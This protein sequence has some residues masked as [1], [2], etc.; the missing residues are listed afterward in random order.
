[1]YHFELSDSNNLVNLSNS[2]LKFFN[3]ETFHKSHLKIDE[4][5]KKSNKKKVCI[6]LFDGFGKAI[7]NKYKDYAPFMHKHIFTT[8]QSVYPPT[9]VAATNALLLGKYPIET[10]YIGWFQYFKKFNKTIAIFPS[11]TKEE[12]KVV[13]EPRITESLLK[14]ES[15]IDI[16]NKKYN[17][18]V[19]D[20][21]LSFNYIKDEDKDFKDFNERWLKEVYNSLDNNLF[22]YAYNISPDHLMHEFGT[23]DERVKEFIIYINNLVEKTVKKY[24]DTLFIAISDHGMVDVKETLFI[25]DIDGFKETLEKPLIILEPR[26]ASLFVKDEEK[27]KEIYRNNTKLNSNFILVS[28]KELLDK[29]IL[30]YSSYLNPIALDTLGDYFLIAHENVI[31]GDKYS[32]EICFKGHHAGINNDEVFIDLQIYND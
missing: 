13:I 20:G 24:P 29:N 27:F 7:L 9:T 22:T 16:I 17:K 2:I 4:I 32:R 26:F 19:A 10:G 23:S 6:F 28:K 8:I 3:C 25:E 14:Y 1:M 31:L 30:G 5:L 18:K 12:N 15:I 11:E 21:I